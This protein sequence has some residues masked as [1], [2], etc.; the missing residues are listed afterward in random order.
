MSLPVIYKVIAWYDVYHFLEFI[1][2]IG[3][4]IWTF[5]IFA[6]WN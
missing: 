5:Y 1:F 6:V 3:G 2:E 4:M